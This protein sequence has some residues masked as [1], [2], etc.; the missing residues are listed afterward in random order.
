M[1]AGE[2]IN[3]LVETK[4]KNLVRCSYLPASGHLT[5]T[6]LMGPRGCPSLTLNQKVIMIL[7]TVYENRSAWASREDHKVK[8]L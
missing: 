1:G 5:A 8:I 7:W 6:G 4:M 2:P 3:E